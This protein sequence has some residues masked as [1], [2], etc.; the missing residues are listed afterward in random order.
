MDS[1]VWCYGEE[2]ALDIG[3]KLCDYRLIVGGFC[4]FGNERFYCK[5]YILRLFEREIIFR[6]LFI[7]KLSK[8]NYNE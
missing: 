8:I 3:G 7:K 5:F 4:C 6:F 2:C 1:W